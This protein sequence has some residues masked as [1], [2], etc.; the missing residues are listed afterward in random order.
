MRVGRRFDWTGVPLFVGM[1][2]LKTPALRHEE[3]ALTK[4]AYVPVRSRN[5]LFCFKRTLG[6]TELTVALNLAH[7]PRRLDEGVIRRRVG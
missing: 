5:D 4:G 1:T 7:D 2:G 3:P 6:E